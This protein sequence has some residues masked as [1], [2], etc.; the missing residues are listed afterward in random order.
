LLIEGESEGALEEPAI[1][2]AVHALERRVEQEPGVGKALSY[3]D[4][5]RTVHLAMNA[6]RPEATDPLPG[7]R[8]L[9]AQYLFLYSVAGGGEELDTWLARH[10][11]ARTCAFSC[12]RIAQPTGSACS[13]A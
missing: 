11:G 9:A 1:L 5:V 12:T 6:D 3:V 8:S 2:Q 13:I 4:F 10:T 7:T